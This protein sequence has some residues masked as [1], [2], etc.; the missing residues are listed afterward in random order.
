MVN[1]K[2]ANNCLPINIIQNDIFKELELKRKIKNY[3][4]ILICY[5][6]F[7]CYII[8]EFKLLLCALLR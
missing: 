1:Y 5:P 6:F 7:L 2:Y 3:I 4:I 8:N